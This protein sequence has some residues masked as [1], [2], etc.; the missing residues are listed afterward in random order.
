MRAAARPTRAAAR[1]RASVR[2]Q[3]HTVTGWVLD[4][5][6]TASPLRAPEVGGAHVDLET[7]RGGELIE[8]DVV[9]DERDVIDVGAGSIALEHVD[10]R[11]VRDAQRGEQHLTS[12]PLVEAF[13]R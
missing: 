1:Q 2:A 5:E 3:L 9:D 10:D 12:A 13:G 6:A 8:V 7:A 4:V 11:R